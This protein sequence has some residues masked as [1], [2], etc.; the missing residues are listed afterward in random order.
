MAGSRSWNA[1]E[2]EATAEQ[3]DFE[4]RRA[5]EA[6]E[7]VARRERARA[8]DGRVDAPPFAHLTT[9]SCY[10]L[11]DGTIRPRELAAAAAAAGMTHVAITDRD[12]L[13]GVVRFAQAAAAEGVTPVFGSDL[14]LEPDLDRP[15]WEVTRAGRERAAPAPATRPRPG[16][17]TRRPTRGGW[18]VPDQP[19][20]AEDP[21]DPRQQRPGRG[22]AWLED[23]AAR[24]TLLA[25]DR[26]GYAAVCR[27]VT[28]AHMGRT[29]GR[30]GRGS[31]HLAWGDVGDL[32]GG[33]G[34][35][36]L[37]GSGS[38]VARLLGTGRLEA[39]EAEL[40]RWMEVVGRQGVLLGVRNHLVPAGGRG[41]RRPDEPGDDVRIR[42]TLALAERLGVRAVAHNDV[43]YLGEED[44]FLA[45][46]LACVR[47]QVPLGAHHIGR[48]TA[49]GWF[50]T[51]ADLAPLFR[52]RPD[53]LAAAHD[54]ATTCEVDLGIGDLHVPRLTGLADEVAAGEL[55]RRAW[56]GVAERYPR[57]TPAVRERLERELAMVDKLGLHDYFLT[58]SR[59]VADIRELGI[60]VACRGS[61]AG[62]LICYALRISDVDPVEHRLAFERFMNPYRD[63]LPDIDIDVESARREDVYDLVM[64]RYGEERT[65]CVAMVETFQAR[66][67]I[68]EVGKVLGLPP[69]EIDH[70]AKSFTHARARDVRAVMDRLPELKGSRIDAGQ[71]ETLFTIVERIDGFPRHLAL[72]PCGILLADTRLTER[73]PLERSAPR[74]EGHPG[75]AMSQFDKDDV[76][77]LGMLKLDVLSVRMLSAMR[78]ALDLIPHSRGEPFHVDDIPDGDEATYDL[79]RSARSIGMFQIE[80]PGQ[81]ELLGRLQPDHFGDLITEISLFRPGPVKADMVSPFVARRHGVEPTVYAHPS[82]EPILGETHGV[83]VYHEQVM[84]V[85]CALTGCDMSYADLLRRQLGDD[86]KA[87]GMKAWALARAV[88]RGF[89]REDA[90]AIWKQVA[91][92]ASFG[93]CKAHA[94]AF[95]VPTYRSAYLKAHFLPEF[96]A[97][98]LTHDPGMYPRRLILDECR[99]FGVAVLPPDLNRSEAS[100]TVEVV[101]RGLA[102]HLLGI[103]GKQPGAPLPPGWTWSDQRAVVR[104]GRG[105]ANLPGAA[106]PGAGST[107][108]PPSGFDAGDAG[109]GYRFAVRVGLQDVKG[110]T[111]DELASLTE[112]RPFTSLDDVRLRAHLSRP[113]AERLAQVGAFDHI[114]GLGRRDG[115]ASRRALRLGVE[116]LWRKAP[117]KGQGAS[118]PAR[119]GGDGPP[120]RPR[121]GPAH[122]HPGRAGPR[123][124]R[125]H[126]DGRQPPRRELLRAAARGARRRPRDRA[127]AP[128]GAEG[129]AGRRREG[130]GAVA[131]AAVGP[132]GAV[133]VA[134]RPHRH[135][136]GD[137]LRADARGQR[138]GRAAR[139]AARGRGSGQPAWPAR[140]H[141]QRRACV[142]PVAA[143]AGVAGGL[144]RRRARRARHPRPPPAQP[145][146]ARRPAGLRVR[147]RLPLTPACRGFVPRSSPQGDVLPTNLLGLGLSGRGVP[148]AAMD[149]VV[150]DWNGTLFADQHLVVD[151]LNVL[152]EREGRP[153]VSMARYRELYCRPVRVFYERLYERPITDDEWHALDHLYHDTYADLLDQA[154]LAGDALHALEAVHAA[155]RTQSLLSMYRHDA[156]LPL[157]ERYELAQW[158]VRIDG[159]RG[160]GGGRKASYLEAHLAEMIHHVG[161]DPSRVLLIGDAVDDAHAAQHVGARVVLVDGGSHPVE[162]LEATGAPVAGSLT[163][164]LALA[165]L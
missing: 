79:I 34:T 108:V 52:E 24:V 11:R 65:A 160:P 72:H 35:Y 154:G 165:G 25:R 127:A 43:R 81:Q 75:Y 9:R 163:D 164:A 103:H 31:P 56:A 118:R 1:A 93:F 159:L 147:P 97:G 158:F 131:A 104:L 84:G 22:P 148:C 21:V 80:S 143:V 86:L 38:P 126:R 155:G 149:H 82:L 106:A 74:G 102:D 55:H 129:R 105:L 13:Y 48:D 51:A 70:V 57:I 64:A 78:H 83:V 137:L 145:R 88:D 98:L 45:D 135:D 90:E 138:L 152:M 91:S 59:I 125:G 92:F 53:L 39:A 4:V 10:S 151:T 47:N 114:G 117:G 133:P 6:A 44:A 15:G 2:A 28:A 46:V 60:L 62:S 99:T 87:P 73:T 162:E 37:L 146:Q 120:R 30:D 94:A 36:V 18:G 144:A 142:G 119:A 122:H 150:W 12:G 19:A 101:D 96:M 124:D 109:N 128:A 76:A 134:R 71:L 29:D 132:A 153:R 121:A 32:L 67:A 16:R 77:A 68:R 17:A 116:E 115:P 54:V 111:A 157:V 41:R 156:L 20:A 69:D 7:D 8:A 66:M 107:P 27:A 139:V 141:R 110:V 63:E 89:R 50:K 5:A 123:R 61:A 14:A 58:V 140:R 85:L 42:H 95:A 136:P 130:R 161:D 26:A 33:G 23:D 112:H 100:Y 3:R 113:T 49:E 40:R